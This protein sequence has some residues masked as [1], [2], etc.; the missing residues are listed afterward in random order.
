[1]NM[2]KKKIW[3]SSGALLSASVLMGMTAYT[4]TRLL[5]KT[6]F[7][8]EAPKVAPVISGAMGQMIAGSLVDQEILT[9]QK[10]AAQRLREQNLKT[11][12]THAHDGIELVGHWYPCKDPKRVV[13]AMHGWR[14][15]WDMGFGLIADFLH[16]NH[17]CVL[18]AEQ[19]G[20]NSSGGDYMGLGVTERFDCL[21]WIRWAIDEWALN[22]PIYLCGVSMG[23]TT[24]L[25]AAGLDL[26]KN[27]HG[28]VADC[29]YTSPDEVGKHIANDNLHLPYH[30]RRKIIAGIYEQKNRIKGFDYSTLDALG[31]SS[32]PVLLIHGTHDQFVPIEM[33]YQ[34]YIACTAPKRLLIVPG[35]G[36][37]LSYLVE[38]DRYE[39]TVKDFWADFD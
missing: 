8:R 37:G 17:C 20:Q 25:M 31:T 36:H 35:A 12:V 1:M 16:D 2:D 4:V 26:P 5:A 11:V 38:K 24:V 9:R 33:T 3:T 34:N 14:S 21:Q 27:V 22:L 7:D 32:V 30:L 6:A 39:K 13:I 19:R 10:G 28:I 15:S 29:A 23:A 18:F